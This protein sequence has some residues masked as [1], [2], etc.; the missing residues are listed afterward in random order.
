M[1]KIYIGV[2]HGGTDGGAVS[3]KGIKESDVNLDM[4]LAIEKYLENYQCEVM[5]SRKNDISK[6]LTQKINE[7]N[8]FAPQVAIEVHNNAGGGDGFEA[9][10]QTNEYEAYSMG[11]AQDIEKYVIE[12]GQN[13]RGLKKKLNA[14][15]KDYFGF[16]RQVNAP[17]VLIEGAFMDTK[18]FEII[19]TL[20]KRQSFGEAIAKGIVSYLNL[21]KITD[22]DATHS[23]DS[24]QIIELKEQNEELEK[25]LKAEVDKSKSYEIS[26]KRIKKIVDE[27]DV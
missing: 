14:Y 13:T 18:D 22:L 2:G 21:K 27:S 16:L 10:Y 7:A 23:A 4:S 15:G 3:P 6:S 11:L 26:L 5:I 12:F 19:D 1:K 9:Y 8:S 17:A 25:L 20:A 24:N